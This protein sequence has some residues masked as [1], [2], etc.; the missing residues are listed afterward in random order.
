M[1]GMITTL[2][3]SIIPAVIAITLHEAA[4][5][6]AAWALGDSTARDA[7]RL[8]L[9]PL[10]HVDRV[11]TI[12][13]PG[14][15][16]IG[17]LLTIGRVEFLFGWAKPVPVNFNKLRGGRL[18][19]AAVAAAGPVTNLALALVAVLA[20]RVVTLLP[21]GGQQWLA[22][23]LRNALQINLLLVVFN[24]IPIPPLDGGRVVV[25]LLPRALSV[26]WARLEQVGLFI[27]L[28]GLFALPMLGNALG[29]DLDLFGHVLNGAVAWLWHHLVALAGPR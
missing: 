3:L 9:N 24:L 28:G 23:N 14:V 17:Q 29:I 25:G 18:G 16:V 2:L 15:L 21:D 4:H 26:R 20:T 7:G 10:R 12:I 11:G 13:L 1:T 5:G 27:I 22:L 6:Y 8:S 19:M